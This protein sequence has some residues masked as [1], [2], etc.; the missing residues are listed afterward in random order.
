MRETAAQGNGGNEPGLPPCSPAATLEPMN[1]MNRLERVDYDDVAEGVRRFCAERLYELEKSLRPLADGTFGEV[2]PGHL[3]GYLALIKQIGALY[4]THKPP[5]E[6]QNVM[7]VSR[8]QQLLAGMEERHQRE[9][10]AVAA[11][12]ETRVRAQLA[13]GSSKTVEQAKQTVFGKL[14]EL[15]TRM[16]G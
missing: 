9:L 5:R 6:L 1:D 2:L 8:V 3:A 12:T 10:E 13:L 14:L 7:P 11:E 15:E 4:Q 16:P